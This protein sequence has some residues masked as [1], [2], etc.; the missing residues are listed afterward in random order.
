MKSV[1]TIE[2]NPT[3]SL[4]M[5]NLLKNDSKYETYFNDEMNKYIKKNK[6][7][8]IKSKKDINFVGKEKIQDKYNLYFNCFI[9]DLYEEQKEKLLN[10]KK[11]LKMKKS[12]SIIKLEVLEDDI[13]PNLYIE[14]IYIPDIGYISF[15]TNKK[16]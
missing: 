14:H 3:T 15:K 6:I 8:K 5:L 12:N 16:N 13:G 1:R 2:Y 7:Q 4:Q 10:E 11:F 9:P